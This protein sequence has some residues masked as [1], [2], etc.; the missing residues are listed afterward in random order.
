MSEFED[1]QQPQRGLSTE[2]GAGPA[3]DQQH[4]LAPIKELPDEEDDSSAGGRNNNVSSTVSLEAP[5][6]GF[7]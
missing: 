5:P 3:G 2:S 1:G 4:P 6:E 7:H